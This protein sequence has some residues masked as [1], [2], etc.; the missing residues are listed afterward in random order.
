MNLNSVTK[1]GN[2]GR[3]FSRI[4]GKSATEEGESRKDQVQVGT[5]I[6]TRI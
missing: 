6:G 3:R 5:H 2:T 4:N 1:K